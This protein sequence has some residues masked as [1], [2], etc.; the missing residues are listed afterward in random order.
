MTRHYMIMIHIMIKFN[1][2]E[3]KLNNKEKLKYYI[4]FTNIIISKL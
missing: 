1:K 3:K 4:L 2:K